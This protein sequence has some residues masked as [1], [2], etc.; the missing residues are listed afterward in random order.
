MSQLSKCPHCNQPVSIPD[1]FDPNARVRC[2][3]CQRDFSLRESMG[4][5]GAPGVAPPGPQPGAGYPYPQQPGYYPQQPGQ[6]YYPQQGQPQQSYGQPAPPYAP[7][8][9][10]QPYPPQQRYA[11]QQAQYPG[12]APPS[13]Y[14]GPGAPQYGQAPQYPQPQQPYAAGP[15]AGQQSGY[16]P[17]LSQQPGPQAPPYAQQTPQQQPYYGQQ[18]P[19]W[20]TP[21]QQPGP[22]AS[23]AAAPPPAQAPIAQPPAS[24]PMAPAAQSPPFAPSE[25]PGG[26]FGAAPEQEAAGEEFMG[27]PGEEAEESDEGALQ[28]DFLNRID[29]GQAPAEQPPVAALEGQMPIVAAETPLAGP[30]AP[31][32]GTAMAATEPAAAAPPPGFESAPPAMDTMV[33]QQPEAMHFATP[34]AGEDWTGQT[35]ADAPTRAAPE[36]WAG[37]AGGVTPI[38]QAPAAPPWGAAAQ[39][40]AAPAQP[41]GTPPAEAAPAAPWGAPPQEA[42]PA[43]PWGAP[44]PEAASAAPPWG[45]APAVPTVEAAPAQPWGQPAA[46]W[47][48]VPQAQPWGAPGA[49]PMPG[50]PVYPGTPE[51]APQHDLDHQIADEGVDPALLGFGGHSAMAAAGAPGAVPG[52]EA[53]P[54]VGRRRRKERS[55]LRDLI[56]AGVGG[57]FGLFIAY[58][59]LSLINSDY[60]VFELQ[61]P[62]IRT[63]SSK[64]KKANRPRKPENEGAALPSLQDDKTQTG[65]GHLRLYSDE[66]VRLI[67]SYSPETLPGRS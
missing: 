22:Q 33:P 39:S 53:M 27:L 26:A 2:P 9:P 13:P 43:Q 32:A 10:Q 65:A 38:S 56:G 5:G 34:G 58:Y 25:M 15:P 8:Q 63:G 55:P 29:S 49:Q 20:F 37:M 42:A 35:M 62:G 45:Q 52:A 67:T 6:P 46:P 14:P 18:Q 30:A 19:P 12:Q 28:F 66:F 23:Q 50:A 48:Q 17:P 3:W 36:G 54:R 24:Q 31:A 11:P 57:F 16:Y 47:G 41:W 51:Q 44:P 60:N 59:L 64:A 61:L 21:P 7:Q 1:G 4:A 40:G